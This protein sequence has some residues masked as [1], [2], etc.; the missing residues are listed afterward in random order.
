M[1]SLPTAARII[2]GAYLP[3][4]IAFNGKD[5]EK[6]KRYGVIVDCSQRE[7]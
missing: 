6:K 2:H 1:R 7:S 3:K 5:P 4:A